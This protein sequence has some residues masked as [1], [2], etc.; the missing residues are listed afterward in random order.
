MNFWKLKRVVNRKS[1]WWFVAGT[2]YE[3]PATNTML[4]G[5]D[6]SRAVTIQRTGTEAYA[7]FLIRA[8]IPL[9][10]ERGHHLRLYFNQPPPANLLPDAAH[11]ET[12]VIPFPRFWT[13]LRLAWELWRRPPDI[14][15][16]PAHVIPLSYHGRA[17]AT[18]HDLGYHHFPEAHPKR[19]LAY[20][21]WSTR[22]NGRRAR[23]IFADSQATKDDLVRF[24]NI[25]A[26]KITV[27]YPG[28]DPGLC[29]VA[30][31]EVVT[32]VLAKYGIIRPY[33]LYI[34][35]LQ[36]RKNLER[37]IEAYAQSGVPHQLV[38]AGKAGWLAQPIFDEIAHYRSRIT[39]HGSRI[40]VTGFVSDE[41]KAALLT[42]ATALL[43]PSLYEGF[44]FPILEAQ[45]CGVPVLTA[46]SSSCPEAAGEAAL[47][48]DPLD[49]QAITAGI[50]Q[51]VEGDALR[52]DLAQKGHENVKRF[53]W[54]DTAAQVLVGLETAVNLHF[55]TS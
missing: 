15:F 46:N 23:I 49:I 16:T 40:T 43:Y 22:H 25:P 38:L 17:A 21:K 50:K 32:A 33:L 55:P 41:D 10:A 28:V 54:R 29:R 42:G 47:F 1:G 4:I 34:S 3:P 36:P 6:A 5:I 19:Q 37:L 13:H 8:L 30:A 39:D 24:D 18:I 2:N 48:V 44:G 12:A 14:F 7:A 45:A 26:E 11:M 35:T 51:L 9:A 53:A 20:L 52:Q 31:E 27:V